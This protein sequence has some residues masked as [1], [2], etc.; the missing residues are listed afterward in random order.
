M[1]ICMKKG[2]DMKQVDT[3][4]L[5]KDI[6]NSLKFYKEILKLE[7]LHDWDSM[8]IFK[9]RLALHQADL[10]KPE[11]IMR[12]IIPDRRLGSG[13]LIIYI[14]L[15]DTDIND[16]FKEIENRDIRIIHK[17]VDLPWQKI[18]RF[19]DPDGHI[20]EIGSPTNE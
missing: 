8:V 5:V 19:Y 9:N 17:V 1:I 3:I 12:G 15:E 16:Y 18:F 7:V 11:K 4:V 10:L 20:I 2:G 13:N 6:K 14:E